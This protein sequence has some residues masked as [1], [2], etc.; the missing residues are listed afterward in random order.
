MDER[1]QRLG[2]DQRRPRHRSAAVCKAADGIA[3]YQNVL[4]AAACSDN[5]AADRST[6]AR[7]TTSRP[8]DRHDPPDTHQT[9]RR[10]ALN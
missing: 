10:T 3:V 1:S 8:T 4:T 2:C 9:L 7:T 5:D 6:A